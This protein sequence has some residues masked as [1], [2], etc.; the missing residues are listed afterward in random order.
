M[1]LR[2]P[3]CRSAITLGAA[4]C[5]VVPFVLRPDQPPGALRSGQAYAIET[6]GGTAR[7]DLRF[8]DETRYLLIVSS[9]APADEEHTV[10]LSARPAERIRHV[11]ARPL[12]PLPPLRPTAARANDPPGAAVGGSSATRVVS[13][14]TPGRERDFYLHVAEGSLDNPRHYARVRGR[15]AGM[16]E[17]VCVYLD[18]RLQPAALAPG[19]V[20]DIIR[21][22]DDEIVP[23]AART[24]GRYRDV[25]GDGRFTVLLTAWLGRLEGGRTSLGGFVRGADFRPDV[26]P[27]FSNRCDMLY[28]NADLRP[29]PHL[30]ALLAHEFAHA[31]CFSERASATAIGTVFPSEDDWLNEAIAHLEENLYDA[32][33]SNLDYRISRYLSDPAR[34][35]LVVPDYYEAG[36]WRNHGCRG[37]TF[38]MLR[39]CVDQFGEDLLRRL[40][41]GPL[42][43]V[44]N[45]EAATGVRFD[46]LY[47]RW[48]VAVAG[49]AA[50]HPGGYQSL[51]LNG[52]LAGWSLAGPRTE[53]WDAAGEVRNLVLKGTATSFVTVHASRAGARSL[54]IAAAPG[55]QLQVTLLPQPPGV[56]QIH[57][58][59]E[60]HLATTRD[61]SRERSEAAGTLRVRAVPSAD[62]LQI[63]WVACEQHDGERRH[64]SRWTADQLPVGGVAIP[65]DANPSSSR[66]AGTLAGFELELPSG[67][68][69]GVPLLVKLAA[70][71]S[72]GRRTVAWARV[73]VP[74]PPAAPI[75]LAA[76]AADRGSPR[77]NNP[78][79]R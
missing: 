63:E 15:I 44:R 3:L 69:A 56:P 31:V 65:L 58:D 71:D 7:L 78:Q 50:G 76:H 29:G 66:R 8:D 52:V 28:L 9:L 43:G 25:D 22:F 30:G 32:S 24:L 68:H 60:W 51:D 61:G 55:T 13:P 39:W 1:A 53:T 72:K 21:R 33:W 54:R 16:G 38:L 48:T 17:H 23:L 41:R 77:R 57:L 20:D 46:E 67:V 18:T 4:V 45:L 59:A 75:R 6:T 79:N 11:P 10:E 27:P 40:V 2:L 37:A 26:D 62:D 49:S 5:A 35:P 70:R 36:L 64:S 19:L 42:P 47:R 34:Y 73:P 12:A 74:L 14:G